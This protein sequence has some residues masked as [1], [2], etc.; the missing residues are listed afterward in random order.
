MMLAIVQKLESF[1]SFSAE[2]GGGGVWPDFQDIRP[3]AGTVI[4]YFACCELKNLSLFSTQ[5][6]PLWSSKP[7]CCAV[8]RSWSAIK[9]T[10]AARTRARPSQRVCVSLSCISA[11]LPACVYVSVLCCISFPFV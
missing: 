1:Q 11:S 10:M 7:H 4:S 6:I 3:R 9:S 5:H 2:S 8:G